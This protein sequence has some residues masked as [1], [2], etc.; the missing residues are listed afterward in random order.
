MTPNVAEKVFLRMLSDGFLQDGQVEIDESSV[1]SVS[2]AEMLIPRDADSMLA[3]NLLA[4]ITKNS[5]GRAYPRIEAEIFVYSKTDEDAR[6][7]LSMI[8]DEALSSTVFGSENPCA[9]AL[10]GSKKLREKMKALSPLLAE[11]I[12]QAKAEEE[13]DLLVSCTSQTEKKRRAAKL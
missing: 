7:V 2:I 6:H 11:R 9:A 5:S 4:E 3:L 10:S 8:I 1:T 13:G 12:S